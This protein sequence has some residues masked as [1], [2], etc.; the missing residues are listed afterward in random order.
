VR[1]TS[2]ILSSTALFALF[3]LLVFALLI[4]P[5][6]AYAQ[7]NNT[8]TTNSQRI[9]VKIT[10]PKVNQTVPIGE[11]TVKGTSSDSP[12]TNCQVFIDLNDTKPMQ[13]VTGVGLGGPKDYS[14]WTFTYTQNYHMIDKGLNELTSKISCYDNLGAGNMTT[15]YYSINITGTDNPT[16]FIPSTGNLSVNNSTTGFQSIAYSTVLPQYSTIDTNNSKSLDENVINNS[17]SLVYEPTGNVYSVNNDNSNDKNDNN[18]RRTSSN[19]GDS[20]HDDDSNSNNNNDNGDDKNK[21]SEKTKSH[22][23]EHS[24]TLKVEKIK[25]TANKLKHEEHH[26]NLSK[27]IHNVVKEKLH[28]MTETISD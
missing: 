18:D 9:G 24:K 23:A 1:K 25:Q 7:L 22:S 16:S 10:S 5:I 20:K 13:N 21:D 12:Q 6:F 3:A 17:E 4:V 8:N 26:K 2:P 15:K 11:L 28:R 27:Y 19:P 14:N